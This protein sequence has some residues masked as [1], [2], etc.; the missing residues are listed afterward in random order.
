MK[1]KLTLFV[2]LLAVIGGESVYFTQYYPEQAEIRKLERLLERKQHYEDVQAA[3]ELEKLPAERLRVLAEKGYPAAQ[4]QLAQVYESNN[5]KEFAKKWYEKAAAQN[6]A[7]AYHQL[8]YLDKQRK[9]EYLEKAVQLGSYNAKHSQALRLVTKG[10]NLSAIMLLT[11][12]A[13][14]GFPASQANLGN[15]YFYGNGVQQDWQKAFYWY[16]EAYKNIKINSSSDFFLLLLGRVDFDIYQNLATLY[17]L[18]LGTPKNEE[19]VEELLNRCNENSICKEK[20][21]ND[22][23]DLKLN[24]LSRDNLPKQPDLQ[25]KIEAIK[26]EL[27][28][29]KDPKVLIK[30]GE[31]EK[32][33]SKAKK[34]FGDACD[35]RSQEGCDKYRDLNQK[36]DT[37][38]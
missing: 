4:F 37:N 16:S 2:L 5:Q 18:G 10:D 19:M 24:I 13:E 36:Q 14:A 26:E 9:D 35:L 38:K 25:E 8:S 11:Q 32:D 6:Y 34:Y 7:E 28:L 27:V 22:I 15:A 3:E 1:K 21:I 30:L 31:L 20:K 17:L 12:N 33:K 29:S 23:T